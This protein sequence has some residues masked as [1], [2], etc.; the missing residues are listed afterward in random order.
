MSLHVIIGAGPVGSATA[1]CPV[2]TAE[3]ES[4][5]SAAHPLAVAWE[6]RRTPGASCST[7]HPGPATMLGQSI[8]AVI[9]STFSVF[10]LSFSAQVLGLD[11]GWFG[12]SAA[13]ATVP[14]NSSSSQSVRPFPVPHWPHANADAT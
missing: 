1:V 7:C 12:I 10:W 3:S 11:H 14:R 13:D 8:I 5:L 9:F 4:G 2:A 6:R